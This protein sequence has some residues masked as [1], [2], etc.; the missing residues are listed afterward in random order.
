MGRFL[1]LVAKQ[2]RVDGG[3]LGLAQLTSHG[4]FSV[5]R[6]GCT[7]E[8]RKSCNEV[9]GSQSAFQI[10]LWLVGRSKQRLESIASCG[11]VEGQ[12]AMCI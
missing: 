6:I 8:Q 12:L 10:V 5:L 3:L 1:L 4:N 9:A 7:N 2:C 11:D